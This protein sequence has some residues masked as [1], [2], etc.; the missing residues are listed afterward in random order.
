MVEKFK[1]SFEGLSLSMRFV[2]P[3]MLLL[4]WTFYQNDQRTIKESLDD[5]KGSQKQVWEKVDGLQTKEA[6]DFDYV[7]QHYVLPK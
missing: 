6:S 7:L 4:G 1:T 3:A 5:I 2:L